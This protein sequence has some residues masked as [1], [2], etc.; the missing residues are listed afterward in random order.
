MKP[1]RTLNSCGVCV[2]VQLEETSLAEM[3]QVVQLQTGIR[4]DRQHFAIEGA[5]PHLACNVV[6]LKGWVLTP[7][8]QV[9]WTPAALRHQLWARY[10][11]TAL[12][13][14]CSNF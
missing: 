13:A 3:Q 12:S 10:P 7:A 14:T 6:M 11:S 4:L 1:A 5:L 2:C 8:A 9:S